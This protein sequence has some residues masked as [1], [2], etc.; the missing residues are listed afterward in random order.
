MIGKM[1][2]KELETKIKNNERPFLLDVREPFERDICK[3]TDDLN[4][5]LKDLPTRAEELDKTKEI[6]IYC[7]SGGRS[8]QACLYLQ[9]QGFTNV[10]NLTGG[11]LAWSDYV[12]PSMPK[13]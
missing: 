9:E 3:L 1:S 8:Q 6:V 10:I 13:Y 12:D 5:P 11:V 4:I 7:R 2:V